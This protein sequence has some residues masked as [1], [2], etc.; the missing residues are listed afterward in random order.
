MLSLDATSSSSLSLG[1]DL[2][3]ATSLGTRDVPSVGKLHDDQFLRPANTAIGERG[4]CIGGR[5]I[6]NF[7]AMFRYGEGTNRAITVREY[8]LPDEARDFA[9]TGKLPATPGKCLL[10]TRY[11][12]TYAYRLAR[13]DP[14]FDSRSRVPI[15]AYSNEVGYTTGEELVESASVVSDDPDGYPTTAL[16]GVDAEFTH[17]EAACGAMGTLIT[18][19]VVGFNSLDYTYVL[20]AGSARIVQDFQ[21]ADRGEGTPRSATA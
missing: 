19:P 8:L 17:T 15:F 13:A 16:L 1:A 10:C 20:E 6:G 4:C 11:F 12:V 9:N 3:P 14:G 2:L 7:L 18:R 5:C 21:R